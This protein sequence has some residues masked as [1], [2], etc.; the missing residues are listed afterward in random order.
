MPYDTFVRSYFGLVAI[1]RAFLNLEK[2]SGRDASNSDVQSEASPQHA[3]HQTHCRFEYLKGDWH[4]AQS[5]DI[6]GLSQNL[7]G[8][9]C[10]HTKQSRGDLRR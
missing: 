1:F 5:P 3:L 10:Q 8:E 6:L 2:F 4:N 9:F 7:I